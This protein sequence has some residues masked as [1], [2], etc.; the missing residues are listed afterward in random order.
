MWIS[1]AEKPGNVIDPSIGG[2]LQIDYVHQIHLKIVIG[3]AVLTTNYGPTS[4]HFETMY[5]QVERP[6][7]SFFV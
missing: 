7:V 6:A 1:H 2:K 5:P 3:Y 4:I